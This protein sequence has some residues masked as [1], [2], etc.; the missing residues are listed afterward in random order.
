MEV[1]NHLVDHK[2]T[3]HWHG[4][5]VEPRND[6]GPHQ[7]IGIDS[8]W[9]ASFRVRDDV[10]TMWYHP[11][12]HHH[13]Q[14][15]VQRGLAGLIITKNAAD[16]VAASLPRDYGLNDFPIIIQDKFIQYDAGEDSSFINDCCSMGTI[17]LVNGTWKPYL[18]VPDQ[19][20]VRFRILNG[21]SERTYAISLQRGADSTALVPFQVIASDA[22]YLNQPYPMNSLPPTPLGNLSQTLM[23]MPGERY[24]IVFKAEGLNGQPLFLVNRRDWMQGND[25]ISTFAGGPC[26]GNPICYSGNYPSLVNPNL[27]MN[28]VCTHND[29]TGWMVPSLSFDQVPMPLLKILPITMPGVPVVAVLPSTLGNWHAPS[30]ETATVIR[31]KNL[32][33]FNPSQE[34]H[35]P[36]FSIDGVDFNLKVIN[37]YIQ[38]GATEIW[39]VYN[40]SGVAHPF[41]V[42][43][44]HFFI[45]KILHYDSSGVVTSID[46]PPYMSGPKDVMPVTSS[47]GNFP[48]SFKLFPQM[49]Y[50]LIGTWTDFSVPLST[51]N[52]YEN[53]YMYHCHILAHEDG[54]MMHQFVVVSDLNTI[55][56]ETPLQPGDW[57][58]YPNPGQDLLYVAGEC[59]AE[60]KIELLDLLGHR[61]A[62][63]VVPPVR[64]KEPAILPVSLPA[65]VYIVYWIRPGKMTTKIW[66]KE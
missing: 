7:M 39:D 21:S 24:E 40:S 4:A 16:P 55:G 60:S 61:V 53:G 2:T 27:F 18:E 65:G 59:E 13:T 20:L 31:E 32:L 51:P 43:D 41:H 64:A 42:H 34:P 63:Y 17:S 48:G 9:K 12:L 8:T 49:R 6:G 26:Y 23:I 33:G 14:E 66:I 52:L 38:L 25:Y 57:Q 47:T 46:V 22:G 19:G 58:I 50:R 62:R 1:T 35:V 10:S 44:I 56:T 11:H 37:D 3:T 5:H 45:T 36:P 28:D 54:G 29:S 30:A 15:Q